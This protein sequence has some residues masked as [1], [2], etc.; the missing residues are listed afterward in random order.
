MPRLHPANERRRNLVSQVQILTR[1][2]WSLVSRLV[3]SMPFSTFTHLRTHSLIPRP[4]TMINTSGK[5]RKK[6]IQTLKVRKHA[7][8]H[9]MPRDAKR[10]QEVHTKVGMIQK[11]ESDHPFPY[12]MHSGVKKCKDRASYLTFVSSLPWLCTFWHAIPR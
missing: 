10:C 4:K 2:G 11:Y 6:K 12:S 8:M 9:G 5:Y 1:A 3:I 7:G